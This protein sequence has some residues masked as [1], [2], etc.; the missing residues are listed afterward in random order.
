[1]KKFFAFTKEKVLLTLIFFIILSY[2][3][4]VPPVLGSLGFGILIILEFIVS[5]FISC[6]VLFLH[7]KHKKK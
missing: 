5:Y 2:L 3:V 1:M 6:M 7:K 4:G